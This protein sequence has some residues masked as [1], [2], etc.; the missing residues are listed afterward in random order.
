MARIQINE[1]NGLEPKLESLE[2]QIQ[3]LKNQIRC[4]QQCNEVLTDRT[5]GVI[6]LMSPSMENKR[7]DSFVCEPPRHC[8]FWTDKEMADLVKRLKGFCEFFAEEWGRTP[9]A[10]ECKLRQYM[11]Q[12]KGDDC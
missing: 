5:N 8:Q 6:N 12:R 4:L 11:R 9:Y 2:T 10:V 1:V 3:S 7:R